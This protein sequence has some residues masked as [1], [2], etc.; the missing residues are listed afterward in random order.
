MRLLPLIASLRQ[1]C[2]CAT[3][4]PNLY[5]VSHV[6]LPQSAEL[7]GTLGAGPNPCPRE[8]EVSHGRL[9]LVAHSLRS[10]LAR[11]REMEVDASYNTSK[12]RE[13]V[14]PRAHARDGGSAKL[15]PSCDRSQDKTRL[16]A[17]EMEAG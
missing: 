8:M 12:M 11:T 9:P 1:R 4:A 6:R 17:R 10:H 13:V 2:A 14:S 7:F 15:D 3:E 5:L 16:V